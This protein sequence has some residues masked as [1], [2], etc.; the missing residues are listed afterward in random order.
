MFMFSGISLIFDG[1]SLIPL[2]GEVDP[3][4]KGLT[5]SDTYTAL[6]GTQE[7]PATELARVISFWLITMLRSWGCFQSTWGLAVL[8]TALLVPF[9]SRYPVHLLY[10][11]LAAVL[12][13]VEASNSYGLP[14]G[15]NPSELHPNHP[16]VRPDHAVIMVIH[17]TLAMLSWRQVQQTVEEGNT[18]K[19]A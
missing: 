8:F 5:I 12:A 4:L 17:L 1:A 10:T 16:L 9:E 2:M 18:Q 11:Y 6:A 13:C 15:H 3:A 19:R 7:A 14:F